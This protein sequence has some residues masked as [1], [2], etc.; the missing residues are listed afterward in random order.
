MAQ[1]INTEWGAFSDGLPLTEFDR[2]MD[3]ASINPGE[4]VNFV[5]IYF[6][7]NSVSTLFFSMLVTT[8]KKTT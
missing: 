2:E 5:Y 7:S 8:N 4:Q 3:A 1:I 6:F